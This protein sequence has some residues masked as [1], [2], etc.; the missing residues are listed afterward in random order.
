MSNVLFCLVSALLGKASFLTSQWQWLF[1]ALLP[2]QSDLT[3]LLYYYYYLLQIIIT[4]INAKHLRTTLE[5]VPRSSAIAHY[6]A[7]VWRYISLP[8][9]LQ[10]TWIYHSYNYSDEKK[11]L[12][13]ISFARVSEYFK[14]FRHF[15]CSF[16]SG[17]EIQSE[18]NTNPIRSAYEVKFKLHWEFRGW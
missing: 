8:T 17:Q 2:I 15:H 14:V 16:M 9:Y 3:Q 1:Q 18:F 4:I 6:T 13:I 11:A 5:I 7:L 12:F 10:S